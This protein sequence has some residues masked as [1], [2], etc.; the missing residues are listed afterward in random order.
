M[1][2]DQKARKAGQI[3]YL[4]AVS[5]LKRT[6]PDQDIEYLYKQQ[7]VGIDPKGRIILRADNATS[8]HSADHSKLFQAVAKE[9]VKCDWANG[10]TFQFSS[11]SCE[12]YSPYKELL[13]VPRYLVNM[14]LPHRKVSGN[15]FSRRNGAQELSLLA[16]RSIGLPYGVYAR[17]ILMYLTTER[18]RSK[19]RQFQLGASWRAFLKKMQI[20]ES[21]PRIQAVQEQL[22][23]LCST[24]YQIHDVRKDS[25]SI[26]NLVVAD[27]WM[28]SEDGVN[29]TLSPSFYLMTGD[30]V[31]PLESR[32]VHK[33]RRS[34][35]MLDLYSWLSCRLFVL[36]KETTIPWHSLENQFGADYR[37]P[38]AFRAKFLLSL[39]TVLK[40]SPLAPQIEIREKGLHLT[41]GSPSDV[42]WMERQVTRACSSNRYP[43]LI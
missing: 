25:E 4:T 22:K 36:R 1:P 40:Q 26:S 18:V 30:S 12:K 33:F 9:L 11:H 32:I 28:R 35:L 19:D 7:P 5:N 2:Y 37:R 38:R 15:E 27:E 31:V 43:I 42:E 17:L 24:L 41:P 21:G 20:T 3:A 13:Y 39:E 10:L 16:A 8:E 34:P 29:I 6:L 14:T 23:R